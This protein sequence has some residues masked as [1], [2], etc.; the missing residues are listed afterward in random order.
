[1]PTERPEIT[2]ERLALYIAQINDPEFT[3][4][5]LQFLH[6]S[7]YPYKSSDTSAPIYDD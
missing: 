4:M 1:M 6:T 2:Q 3:M 5:V 7:N